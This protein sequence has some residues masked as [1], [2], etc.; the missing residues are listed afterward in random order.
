MEAARQEGR[1]IGRMSSRNAARLA[2]ALSAASLSLTLLTLLMSFVGW[3]T[4]LPTLWYS[5]SS[6]AVEAVGYVG[7]PILGGLVAS[8]LPGNPYGWLWLGFGSSVAI[9]TFGGT[10]AAFALT[11]RSDL[12]PAPLLTRAVGETVGFVGAVTTLP[13]LLLLFPDGRLPSRRW[14][15]PAWVIVSVATV[16]GI[17]APFQNDRSEY[18]P[19]KD[20][21]AVGMAF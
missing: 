4:S 3:A 20:P 8:R 19:Y 12:L 1:G 13:F 18:A 15:F 2:W 21:L 9:L 6:N 5:W 17:A 14:R 16:L 10:Y 7:A 11:T